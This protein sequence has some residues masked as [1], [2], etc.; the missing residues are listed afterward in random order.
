MARVAWK[1]HHLV[2]CD[3]LLRMRAVAAVRLIESVFCPAPAC[4][5]RTPKNRPRRRRNSRI[6]QNRRHGRRQGMVAVTQ[7]RCQSNEKRAARRILCRKTPA[8]HVFE[9]ASECAA[10][11]STRKECGRVHHAHSHTTVG[12][13]RS[14]KAVRAAAADAA[15]VLRDRV[16]PLLKKSEGRRSRNEPGCRRDEG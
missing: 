9:R 2:K 12:R 7:A 5:M 15:V 16:E 10:H 4:G 8:G 14:R 11:K 3:A 6:L 13:R 1:P